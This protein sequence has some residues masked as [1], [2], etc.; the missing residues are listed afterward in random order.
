[1]LVLGRIG[2]EIKEGILTGAPVVIGAAWASIAATR[3]R[4]TSPVSAG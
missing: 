3:T 4:S 1:M 2:L